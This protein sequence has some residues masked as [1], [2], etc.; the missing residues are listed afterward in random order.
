MNAFK[1]SDA[2]DRDDPLD[3]AQPP[4]LLERHLRALR[5][6]LLTLSVA[7]PMVAVGI[8]HREGASLLFLV[9]S[10]L[11]LGV[12][13]G[14]GLFFRGHKRLSAHVATYTIVFGSMVAV[15][16][17][18]SVRSGAVMALVGGVVTAGA[19]LPRRALH[20][21][22]G[23]SIIGL[24]LL[25]LAENHGLM[26][27][28]NLAPDFS[29]W[30]TQ[31]SVLV[32]VVV[33]LFHGRERT[34]HAFINQEQAL[35]R[36]SA[37]EAELRTSQ[38][39]FMAMFQGNPAATM[40][41]LLNTR[42]VVGANEAFARVFGYASE[43]LLG[44]V[45]PNLWGNQD[46]RRRF[47]EQLTH[48]NH[49]RGF[50]T[51]G[52]R[53]NGETFDA[54]VYCEII[55][56]GNERLMITM[57]LDMSAE[58]ASRLA[59]E[60]SEERFSKAFNFSPLGMTITR[61]RDGRFM[62]VNPA[63]ERVLGYTQADFTGKTAMEAGVWLNEEDRMDYVNT[64]RRDGKLVAYETRMRTKSGQ[65]VDVRV[66]AETIDIDGE[67]CALSFTLNVAEEKRREALMLN[68]AEGVSGETGEA[69]FRSLAKH[70]AMAIGADGVMV[71]ELDEQRRIHSLAALWQGEL[72]PSITME[73]D[74]TA[75]ARALVQQEMLIL[76]NPV[77]TRMPLAPPFNDVPL[78]AFAGLPLRD[79]DGTAVGLMTVMWR[80]DPKP[81]QNLQALLTIFASRCNAELLRLRRDRE[82]QKLHDTLEHRVAAR[83]DQLQYLNR[84]LDS[85]AYTVSH[86]LK[87]PL[88]AIDGFTHLLHEQMEDRLTDMDRDLFGRIDSSVQRMHSLITDLLALARVSQGSLQR[89]DVNLSDVADDVIRQERH[90]DPS[91]TVQVRIA[92]K[93]MAN[94]DPRMAQIVLENLLGNAWKYSRHTE[95]PTIEVGAVKQP[96]GQ[97]P[98]FFV[99]D[100][101]AGF[102]MSRADR[103]FKPFNRL[104]SANEFEGSGVG[105][106][107]VRR[108]L[109]RHGGFIHGEGHVG[110]GS[111]FEFSFGSDPL[112]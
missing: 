36:A 73:L 30:V 19:F 68:V 85:F 70:L 102:D 79:A 97:P 9:A 100:N 103:L 109:E 35:K 60:K 45:P 93:L 39:R 86:D 61:L 76:E 2:A 63:N 46:D 3:S 49:V 69:F 31:A 28:P 107:T 95:L 84:E 67:P 75:C 18:G 24:A 71:S 47:R 5:A 72:Q 37:V 112:S 82:I 17:H 78:R 62:E 77:P 111:V 10:V 7:V 14:T 92:P 34:R 26:R 54:L 27:T 88:R 4:L 33:S 66:W 13:L 41:Q 38:A 94:C 42:E 105:L 59:L 58:A 6:L 12:W 40:V 55:K 74:S 99:R 64:L 43:A 16:A 25:S 83:T 50:K 11:A 106:A 81:Q 52:L 15:V 91:R 98:V 29:L 56:E 65:A 104:H 53:S 96:P 90:R 110:Q 23:M 101:G 51:R 22:T 87:S 48:S 32:A 20:L 8:L 21:I 1:A 57:V 80:N 89:T 108:I 44:T